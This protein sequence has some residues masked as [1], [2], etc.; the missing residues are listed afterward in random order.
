MSRHRDD[1][2]TFERMRREVGKGHA[3]AANKS[4]DKRKIKRLASEKH[5]HGKT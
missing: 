3:R 1:E 4:R 5:D 2:D